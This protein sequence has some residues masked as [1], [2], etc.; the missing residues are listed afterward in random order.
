MQFMGIKKT[1]CRALTEG[2]SF[3][4]NNIFTND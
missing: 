2:F 3:L 1:F 4:E